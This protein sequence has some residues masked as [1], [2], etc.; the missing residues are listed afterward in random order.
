MVVEILVVLGLCASASAFASTL[1]SPEPRVFGLAFLRAA[2][3]FLPLAIAL[4]FSQGL[5]SFILKRF[6]PLI[7]VPSSLLVALLL[8]AAGSGGGML[9]L[10][11]ADA[12][13]LIPQ[14]GL[15]LERSSRSSWQ[16]H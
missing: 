15:P 16:G 4:G 7:A 12:V 3:T 1:S 2:F 8:A 13:Q 14:I 9:D 10:P 5:H 6:S 11:A